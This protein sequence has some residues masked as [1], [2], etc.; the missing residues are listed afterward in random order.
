MGKVREGMARSK[1]ERERKGA[2][3]TRV[4]VVRAIVEDE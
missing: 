1:S 4:Y 2:S 3:I